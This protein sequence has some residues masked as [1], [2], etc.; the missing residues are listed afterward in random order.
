MLRVLAQLAELLGFRRHEGSGG[1]NNLKTLLEQKQKLNYCLSYL[2][3]KQRDLQ[4]EASTTQS[5]DGRL[6]LARRIKGLRST[7]ASQAGLYHNIDTTIDAVV[8]ASISEKSSAALRQATHAIDGDKLYEQV[9]E[10]RA[11]VDDMLESVD[12]ISTLFS[13]DDDDDDDTEELLALLEEHTAEEEHTTKEETTDYIRT[14]GIDFPEPGTHEPSRS[15]R[16][17]LCNLR[18]DGGRGGVLAVAAD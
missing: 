8:L 18:A 12:E 6:R 2:K 11:R 5:K 14:R 1:E 10:T 17:L 15:E 16:S 13:T 9:A 4:K 7:I 3:H